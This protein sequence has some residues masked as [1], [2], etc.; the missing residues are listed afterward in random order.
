MMV[1]STRKSGKD[2]K[3]KVIPKID[4]F[5]T[6]NMRL[7][8]RKFSFLSLKNRKFNDNYVINYFP[9]EVKGEREMVIII[10]YDTDSQRIITLSISR[11]VMLLLIADKET[12]SLEDWLDTAL[13]E[14]YPEWDNFS[15]H[16]GEVLFEVRKSIRLT[17][18]ITEFALGIMEKMKTT[19][20]Y[21]GGCQS[22][23]DQLVSN[24]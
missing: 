5:S 19:K 24:G 13:S 6:E 16:E 17:S 2:I 9:E 11:D 12:I 10:N 1:V 15:L 8:E 3:F 22:V 14:R 20:G 7:I 23:G 4:T 21:Q 18:I